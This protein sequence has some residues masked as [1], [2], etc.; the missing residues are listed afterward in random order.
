MTTTPDADVRAALEAAGGAPSLQLDAELVLDRGHRVVG[1]RRVLGGAVGAAVTAVVAVV[2]VQL[3]SGQTRALPPSGDPSR[4]TTAV[5]SRSL[6]GTT[7]GDGIKE[8]PGFEVTV[9]PGAGGRVIET[10]TLSSGA[11]V[12]KKVTRTVPAPADGRASF[13]M[14][15]ESG[16]GNV[17]YGYAL[18]GEQGP[19]SGVVMAQVITAPD[20][21]TGQGEGG[22]LRDDASG[23]VVGNLF[24]YRLEQA[25]PAQ[26]I[27]LIWNRTKI[28]GNGVRWL[29]EGAALRAGRDGGADAAVVTASPHLSVLVWR[30]G[31]RFGFG[32]HS[33]G[34]GFDDAGPLQVGVEPHSTA[35]P[36]TAPDLA[37]G[38]VGS[39]SVE[40]A[41][42]DPRDS[43]TV[44]YGDPV[45]GRT[46]FVA[47]STNPD[48][49]GTVT[50]TGGGE[51]QNVTTW[52]VQ[53]S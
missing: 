44:V 49:K 17:V 36:G 24:R 40:L 18:T 46:P 26:V 53:P 43:F 10:W 45:G 22:Q 2:A 30:D 42:T 51:S 13:L 23:R 4:S 20:L 15:E 28:E 41:S 9:E 8:G 14:P 48:V 3:G 16:Q 19:A 31:D 34:S 32:R 21:F 50:V 52:D 33:G 47:V 1:R 35:A 29:G 39:G 11:T 6:H 37:V 27:G 5:A 12:L 25:D 38:W 7:A